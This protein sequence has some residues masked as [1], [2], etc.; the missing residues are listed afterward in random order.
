MVA[1]LTVIGTAPFFIAQHVLTVKKMHDEKTLGLDI[2]WCSLVALF[3]FTFATNPLI[4]FMRLPRYRKTFCILYLRKQ[5]NWLPGSLIA[6]ADSVKIHNFSLWKYF[7][8]YNRS[9]ACCLEEADAFRIV[10]VCR[11]RGGWGDC[12]PTGLLN[13]WFIILL[14]L[15]FLLF[16]SYKHM[17]ICL[18]IISF[19]KL[20][21]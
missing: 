21:N 6:N 7:N 15:L 3:Y 17:F 12:D 9:M 1:C 8:Y 16:V 5:S 10:L 2:L 11:N 20:I 19:C 13:A 18:L 14:A 4:Y